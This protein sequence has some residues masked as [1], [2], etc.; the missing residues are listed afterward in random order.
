MDISNILIVGITGKQSRRVKHVPPS[1]LLCE[2][3]TMFFDLNQFFSCMRRTGV[4]LSSAAG[5]FNM[6]NLS[7]NPTASRKPRDDIFVA[8]FLVGQANCKKLLDKAPVSSMYLVHVVVETTQRSHSSPKFSWLQWE[9]GCPTQL[10]AA[11]QLMH[12]WFCA[13]GSPPKPQHWP[14]TSL[15][16]W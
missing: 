5:P 11:L 15:L 6:F 13:F 2:N 14:S 3:E 12:N 1:H 9:H 4:C 8:T 10:P 7:P 16:Q